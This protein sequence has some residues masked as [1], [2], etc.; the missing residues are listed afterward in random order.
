MNQWHEANGRTL[1]EK[2][3]EPDS[4]GQKTTDAYIRMIL[5]ENANPG[6]VGELN[7]ECDKRLTRW[8]HMIAWDAEWAICQ[9]YDDEMEILHRARTM[10]LTMHEKAGV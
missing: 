9:R 8:I 7:F 2:L 6:T 3:L 4:R 1:A 5:R 10:A